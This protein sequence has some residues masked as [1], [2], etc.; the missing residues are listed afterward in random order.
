MTTHK[1]RIM[2]FQI[3][4]I[5]FVEI[6]ERSGALCW[7]AGGGAGA[8]PALS[9]R[10]MPWSGMQEAEHQPPAGSPLPAGSLYLLLN[11]WRPQRLSSAI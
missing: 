7:R 9:P 2:P 1:L 11:F 4:L 8:A 5:V 10:A 3:K 6:R